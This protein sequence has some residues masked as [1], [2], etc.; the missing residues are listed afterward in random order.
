MDV[1]ALTPSVDFA[2][3]AD[4]LH[5][6]GGKLYVLGGGWDT[7]WVRSFPARHHSLAIGVRV[8]VPWTDADRPMQ[9]TIDLVDEDGHPVFNTLHHEFRVSRPRGLPDGSD[10]GVVRAFTFNNVPFQTA[11]AFGFVLSIDGVER[12]RLRFQVRQRQD[13]KP[14]AE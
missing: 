12:K 7:L 14:N 5:A 10:I 11:G 9:L 8:R 1:P 6:S 4:A 2:L 13:V 3:L